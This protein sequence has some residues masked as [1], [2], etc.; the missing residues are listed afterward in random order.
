MTETKDIYY[1]MLDSPAI[2]VSGTR[3][4]RQTNKPRREH[5][6]LESALTEAKRLNEKTGYKALILKVVEVVQ[7]H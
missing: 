3:K 6:S 2:K 1:I 5:K 4:V 7:C